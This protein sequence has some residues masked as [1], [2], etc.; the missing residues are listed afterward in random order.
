MQEG[1]TMAQLPRTG[2]IWHELMT[3]DTEGARAFYQQVTGLAHETDRIRGG[4]GQRGRI[5]KRTVDRPRM[6]ADHLLH[7]RRLAALARAIHEHDRR[8]RQRV[9]HLVIQTACIHGNNY[10][11]PWQNCNSVVV[12][13]GAWH[14]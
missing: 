13:R 12:T 4:C 1:E 7:Q 2:F 3:T 8:I 11:M 9:R 5:V 6:V 14:G 10:A